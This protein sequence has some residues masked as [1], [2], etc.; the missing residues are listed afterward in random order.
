MITLLIG[1]NS[2]EI[3]RFLAGIS[4]AFNGEAERI[5][6]ESL[7]LSQLPDILMGTS[8]FATERL[9]VVR[10]LGENKSVWPV[11]GDWMDRVSDDIHLVIIESKPDKR[12][13]TFK[14]L[15]KAAQVKEFSAWTDRDYLVA[16]KWVVGESD[17]LG[18]NLDK[19]SAQSLVQRVGVDQ[20]QLANALEKLSLVD[21]ISL[22]IINDLIEANPVENVFNLFELA[23]KSDIGKLQGTLEILEQTE[24]AYRL[25]ALISTQA[26]QMA[27]IAAAS[28]GDNVA[29][30]FGIH[31]YVVSKLEQIV[32]KIGRN[33]VNKIL[34]IFAE[35]DD[36]MKKSRAE[37]WFLVERALLKMA[38]I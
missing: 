14:A 15:K 16:E 20:W 28:D 5:S 22:D 33:N 21:D 31:P 25:F 29:K 26:F 7:Q 37:P 3:E 34:E 6:G 4:S 17:K 32:K 12:T 9:V 36:D 30:D 10:N 38:K 35:A 11:F 27:V 1:D 13:S 23:I 19:K 8:L 2:F 24:D 18:M